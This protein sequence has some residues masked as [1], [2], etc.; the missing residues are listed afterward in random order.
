MEK[1]LQEEKDAKRTALP[2]DYNDYISAASKVFEK[3][4]KDYN[5]GPRAKSFTSEQSWLLQNLRRLLGDSNLKQQQNDIS[6]LF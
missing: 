3:D 5:A 6:R 1:Y 4:L 2:T